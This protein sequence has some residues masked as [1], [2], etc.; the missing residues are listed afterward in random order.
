MMLLALPLLIF[1]LGL[2]TL[3]INAILLYVVGL[4]MGRYFEVDSFWAAF[5]GAPGHQSGLPYPQHPNG[6]GK[7]Q[8]SCPQRRGPLTT[9]TVRRGTAR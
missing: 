5:L 1:T 2:F 8:N 7:L 3:V 4:L 6:D 9:R